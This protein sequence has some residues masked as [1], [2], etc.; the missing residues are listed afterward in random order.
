MIAVVHY[1][2]WLVGYWQVVGLGLLL[3]GFVCH[4]QYLML[5]FS[6]F[7][8]PKYRSFLCS[9]VT[10]LNL[11]CETFFLPD[12]AFLLCFFAEFT[13]SLIL[14]LMISHLQGEPW[15]Q[16]N[17]LIIKVFRVLI[18]VWILVLHLIPYLRQTLSLF[19]C[20]FFQ[21]IIDKTFSFLMCSQ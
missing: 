1:Y 3:F 19:G 9:F 8:N 21:A 7:I 4:C 20:L 5:F 2:N 11:T 14:S 16:I 13:I 17:F 18:S 6:T 15:T 10:C 12:P